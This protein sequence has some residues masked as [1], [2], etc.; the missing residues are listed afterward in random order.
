M[1]KQNKQTKKLVKTQTVGKKQTQFNWWEFR[2]P[3]A[4]QWRIK[5]QK[6]RKTQVR[7]Q[8]F[9]FL[10]T[11]THTLSMPLTVTT[12]FKA[13]AYQSEFTL[14][15][16]SQYIIQTLKDKGISLKLQHIFIK[17]QYDQ[18]IAV[19]WKSFTW[20]V[21]TD[22]FTHIWICHFFIKRYWIKTK[23]L[24]FCKVIHYTKQPPNSFQML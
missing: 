3:R 7:R 21:W 4:K 18:I 1:K 17:A 15:H 20:K 9:I 16:V 2:W 22:I 23:N 19:M 10:C 11:S 13:S 12:A 8:E 24:L 5:A 14:L 6:A